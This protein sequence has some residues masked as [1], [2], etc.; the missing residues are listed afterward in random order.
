MQRTIIGFGV[1]ELGDPIAW[2]DCGHPQHVRHEPPLMARPWVLSEAGRARRLGASL[3]CVRCD[4]F[5]LPP[6]FVAY[7]R[8]PTWTE[9][10]LPAA[11]RR[12]HST[13]SGVWAKIHV[14][15]GTLRYRVPSLNTTVDLT[16]ARPG[17]VVPQVLHAVEPLGAVRVWVEF[18]H[19]PPEN[20]S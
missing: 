8:T 4:R 3:N 12:D 10:T 18:W 17:I 19:A 2:L 20:A 14:E 5:E 16:P 15:Q 11:L 6:H 9:T 7:K 1:D 13:K